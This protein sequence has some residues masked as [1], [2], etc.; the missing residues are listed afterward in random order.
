MSNANI[1]PNV[2]PPK[3]EDP[4]APLERF[5]PKWAMVPLSLLLLTLAILFLILGIFWPNMFVNAFAR[6]SLRS[7]DIIV[8]FSFLFRS[9]CTA[10]HARRP[11][12]GKPICQGDWPYRA[13]L[14]SHVVPEHRSPRSHAN[15]SAVLL[16]SRKRGPWCISPAPFSSRRATATLIGGW[17]KIGQGRRLA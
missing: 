6:V 11:V 7:L 14:S 1:P 4:G 8:L 9:L 12:H 16:V 10:N 15:D 17:Q 13:F 5:F 3:P 2:P